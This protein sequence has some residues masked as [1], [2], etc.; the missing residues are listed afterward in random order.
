MKLRTGYPSRI[1]EGYAF[2]LQ[3]SPL[4]F[5]AP[6]VAAKMSVR[7]NGSVTRHDKGKRVV[8]QGI[9][10]G[11]RSVPFP[12]IFCDELIGTDAPPWNPVLCTKNKLLKLSTQA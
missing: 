3:Q 5:E 2:L 8:C 10:H 4:H 9:P 11:P 1:V 6:L 12:Q 7:A